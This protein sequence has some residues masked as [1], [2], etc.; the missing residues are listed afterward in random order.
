MGECFGRDLE[1]VERF[2]IATKEACALHSNESRS[3]MASIKFERDYP[4]QEDVSM[5]RDILKPPGI[6]SKV[7]S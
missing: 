5:A 4:T 7:L 2:I 1:V 3:E 6:L